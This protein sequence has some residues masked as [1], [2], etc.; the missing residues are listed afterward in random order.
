MRDL[1]DGDDF[2]PLKVLHRHIHHELD[3]SQNSLEMNVSS[4]NIS[5]SEFFEL[6]GTAI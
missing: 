3:Y 2:S 1:I 4:N 5:E 6:S